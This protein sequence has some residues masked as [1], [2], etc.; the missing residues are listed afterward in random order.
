VAQD[1]RF[2]LSGASAPEPD[3]TAET[4]SSIAGD[5]AEAL[6]AALGRLTRAGKISMRFDYKRLEQMDSPVGSEADG[7]IW[8]YGGIALALAVWWFAGWQ[9]AAAVAVVG[10]AAYMTLGR[11]YIRRRI[12]HRVEN[13]ALVRLE[14]WR[15]LWRFGGVTLVVPGGEDCAAPAGN[16]M[17]LMRRIR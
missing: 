14:L 13:Q 6:F 7:N 16:W 4:E 17:A 2:P 1:G 10:I 15:K 8:A 12:R 3:I 9:A 5:D 11:A